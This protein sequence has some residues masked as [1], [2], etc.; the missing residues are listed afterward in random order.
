[1]AMVGGDSSVLAVDL[2]TGKEG[3]VSV[4]N[5]RLFRISIHEAEKEY[6]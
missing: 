4:V 3:A 6:L 1:M 5:G 2:N